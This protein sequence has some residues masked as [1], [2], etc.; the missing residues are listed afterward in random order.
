LLNK[1]GKQAILINKEARGWK[2]TQMLEVVKEGCF[3]TRGGQARH[4]GQRG[5]SSSSIHNPPY[6]ML[7]AVTPN[8]LSFKKSNIF[9]G[10]FLRQ[11]QDTRATARFTFA[12]KFHNLLTLPIRWK[13]N[14]E[15]SG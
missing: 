3:L 13:F 4:R 8:F 6:F 10:V 15:A 9:S 5:T 7:H 2:V 14:S 12:S 11:G 1:N